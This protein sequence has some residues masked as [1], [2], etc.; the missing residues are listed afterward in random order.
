MWETYQHLLQ[1]KFD[2]EKTEC[3]YKS[4]EV[5]LESVLEVKVKESEQKKVSELS[6]VLSEEKFLSGSAIVEKQKGK[7]TSITKSKD[8][9][10]DSYR[11]NYLNFAMSSIYCFMQ[12]NQSAI[13]LILNCSIPMIGC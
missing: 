10:R 7:P 13:I 8:V 12:V 2:K 11:T 5:K 3:S 1:Q 6:K 9:R 4:V